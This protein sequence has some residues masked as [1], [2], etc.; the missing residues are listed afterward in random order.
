MKAGL[1]LNDIIWRLLGRKPRTEQSRAVRGRGPVTH[2]IL[3]DGT[4]SSLDPGEETNVGLTYRLLSEL[5]P[6][7]DLSLFYEAGIQWHS[8]IR[9]TDVI[10]GRGINRQI[11]RA[12]GVLA[13]R[14]R[15]GD[16][17]F[18]LGY[19]R[20]AY[21]VRSLAGVIDR[22]GL[23]KA[24]HATERYVREAYRHYERAETTGSEAVFRARHCHEQ[25]PIEM[26]G[27][28]DTVKALGLRVP[29]LWWLSRHDQEFHSHHLGA[30]VRHGFHALA[31]GE[32]RVAFEPVLWETGPAW[33]G[34]DVE[35]MWF[36]GAHGDVGGQLGG[37]DAARPLSN[38]PLLWMLEKA[39]GCGL[40]LPSGWRSRFHADAKAPS[41]GTFRGWG[42]MFLYR[43]P[44]V[45]GRDPSEFIHR[46]AAGE[47]D[48]PLRQPPVAPPRRLARRAFLNRSR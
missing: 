11:Q 47:R 20:G 8:W 36:R 28:W 4:M 34:Y 21:A 44:R 25:V 13:S 6:A 9:T 12:Y 23:L 19:S 39:E 29:L 24:Q 45:V 48:A 1:R 32:T 7:P 27:V 2:V 15:P 46:S 42:K 26:I 37:F 38:I 17:I 18:L 31:L 10:H 14:Y 16:R 41:V 43:R 33:P 22:I 40:R 5:A 35:Q 3:L 30:S